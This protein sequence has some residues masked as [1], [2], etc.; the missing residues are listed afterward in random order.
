MRE[1]WQSTIAEAKEMDANNVTSAAWS[2]RL[3]KTPADPLGTTTTSNF[4]KL[5]RRVER[6]DGGGCPVLAIAITTKCYLPPANLRAEIQRVADNHTVGGPI[7]RLAQRLYPDVALED[8]R[9]E[10]QT[11]EEDD[12]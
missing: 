6:G 9:D 2:Q 8:L 11:G 7:E 5:I 10:L 1:L 12:D 4:E 3:K